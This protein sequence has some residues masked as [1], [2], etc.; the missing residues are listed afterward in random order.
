VIQ[1]KNG[2]DFIFKID[3]EDGSRE[4]QDGGI[5]VLV[6]DNQGTYRIAG[7][8]VARS[9]RLV[10]APPRPP[11]FDEG[12]IPKAKAVREAQERRKAQV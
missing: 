10:E 8:K 7:Q 6:P 11:K 2:R 1:T 12:S 5:N 4:A 3:D 9:F